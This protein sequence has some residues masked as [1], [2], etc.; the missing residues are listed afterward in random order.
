MMSKAAAS[1][2][3]RSLGFHSPAKKD[4][5]SDGQDNKPQTEDLR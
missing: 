2:L 5:R 3:K 4:F 1:G